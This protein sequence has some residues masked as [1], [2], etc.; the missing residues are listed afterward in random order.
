MTT[1]LKFNK[2]RFRKNLAVFDFDWTLVKP[3]N[4]STFPHHKDDWQWLRP[5]VVVT[6]EALYKKGYA[7]VIVTNQKKMKDWKLELIRSALGSLTMP[8]ICCIATDPAF[9]KPDTRLF[10][11]FLQAKKFSTK[12]FFCGDALGRVN[13]FS[14]SDRRFAEALKLPI[15]TPEELFPF[16]K[17]EEQN[18]KQEEVQVLEQGIVVLVGY[19]GSGKTSI[20]AERYPGA[21]VLHGD[22][23][24]TQAR[25]VKAARLALT[26]T[27]EKPQTPHTI[28]IDATNASAEKRKVYIE[29]AREF[30]LPATCLWVKTSMEESLY[31][32]NL[33]P[34]D[35]VV[36]KIA[37]HMFNKH[38]Q[39]PSIAEGFNRIISG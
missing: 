2:F 7:I 21:L 17:R 28:V 11:E 25:I 18:H 36:P 24:K 29:L 30:H 26:Q 35:A 32:N 37:Y 10:N 15:K 12:S 14:D 31:R 9:A 20:A 13:D 34:R 22:D 4:G 23:L 5:S 16:P 8:S 1:I 27:P 33:R 6:L 39:D 38:F 19:P 3:L